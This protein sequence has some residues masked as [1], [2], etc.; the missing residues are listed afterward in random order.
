MPRYRSSRPSKRRLLKIKA[1]KRRGKTCSDDPHACACMSTYTH[2]HVH[3]TTH[4][5]MHVYLHACACTSNYTRV[6]THLLTWVPLPPLFRFLYWKT[7]CVFL[8][9]ETPTQG[10]ALPSWGSCVS[11]DTPDIRVV[12][13]ARWLVPGT[14][15]L[16][17][18]CLCLYLS[19]FSSTV[20]WILGVWSI[21]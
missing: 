3:L 2:V 21:I 20:S 6:H 15:H 11:T 14:W 10:P 5:C 1:K 17:R 12:G 16:L 9:P 13:R 7:R 8:V 4:V 19:V 18:S